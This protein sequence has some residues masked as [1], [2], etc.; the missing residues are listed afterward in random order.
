MASSNLGGKILA[1]NTVLFQI[2]SIISYS[3]DGI[4]NTAS[5]FSGRARGVN[6][7]TSYE[8]LLGIKLYFGEESLLF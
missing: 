6:D 2:M 4:A 3:F 1:A 8:K 5:V 7:N